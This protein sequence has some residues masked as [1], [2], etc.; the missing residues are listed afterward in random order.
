MLLILVKMVLA[1]TSLTSRSMLKQVEVSSVSTTMKENR[2]TMKS[3]LSRGIMIS[4]YVRNVRG[5]YLMLKMN[6]YG[7]YH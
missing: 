3:N 7:F 5:G 4:S 2:S 1:I 6:R